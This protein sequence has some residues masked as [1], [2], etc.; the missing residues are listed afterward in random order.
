MIE[1]NC[2]NCGE[3]MEA[4]QS[5]AG[6]AI[7]CPQCN[8][9]ES[10]LDPAKP[11]NTYLISCPACQN[12]ISPNARNCPH[13]GEPMS[14]APQKVQTVEQTSKTWKAVQLLGALGAVVGV[15]GSIVSESPTGKRDF[16]TMI[17]LGLLAFVF[18][19]LC[20]WWYHG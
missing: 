14:I 1:F 3:R 12:Q 8:H 5:L 11:T 9:A 16:G 13:C 17:G 10:V 20:A 19:R 15:I 4:P 6:Q 2:S 18:A 7:E